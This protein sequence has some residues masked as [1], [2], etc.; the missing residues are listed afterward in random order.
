MEIFTILRN[1]DLVD[2]YIIAN[3]EDDRDHVDNVTKS[4]GLSSIE[5]IFASNPLGSDKSQLYQF[6][7]TQVDSRLNV[8]L[9]LAVKG[10]Q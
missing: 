9:H 6:Y 8:L 3:N 4:F 10:Q 1:D 7:L 5:T 2:I